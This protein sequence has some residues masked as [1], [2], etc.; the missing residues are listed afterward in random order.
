M[1]HDHQSLE[2]RPRVLRNAILTGIG[3]AIFSVAGLWMILSGEQI[4]VGLLSLAFFGGGGLYAIPRMLRRTVSL[5]LTREGIEWR[6]PQGKAV[7]PWV[8]VESIG[9]VSLFSNKMVGIRL[10]SYDRYLNEMSPEVARLFAKSLPYMKFAARAT[11]LLDTPAAIA[12]WSKRDGAD[13]SGTLA[14]FSTVG[15]LAEG[16]VWARTNYGYELLLSW[17]DIDRPPA[18]FVTLLEEYRSRA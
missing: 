16:L 6:Y 18:K 4:L 1:T 13:P 5:E 7:V 2:V 9:I 10:R 3:C 12:L 11:S 17:A 15:N 14:S 8:D